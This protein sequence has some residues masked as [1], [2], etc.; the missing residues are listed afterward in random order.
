MNQ[1]TRYVLGIYQLGVLI[2]DSLEYG[3]TKEK[4]DLKIYNTRKANIKHCVEDNSPFMHFISQQKEIGQEIKNNVLNFIDLVYGDESRVAHVENNELIVD[5][6]FST[7]VFDYIVG[8]H[9]TISDIVKGYVNQSK[10]NN[11]Y[12]EKLERLVE[13]DDLFYRCI[14]SLVLTDAIHR[15]YLEF[16][17]EMQQSKGQTTPQ[18]T[19]VNNELNKVVGYFN[20]VQEHSKIND[21]EFVKEHPVMAEEKYSKNVEA[22]KRVLSL[23]GGKEKLIEGE[24]LRDVIMHAHEEWA[25][26][27][28][29]K[30]Y[31]WRA[32]YVDIWQELTDF[33]KSLKQ[34]VPTDNGNKAN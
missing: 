31:D 34:A 26:L 8:L 18:A 11:T 29:V 6:A 4:Y 22:S 2:R 10:T 14:T 30:E 25:K 5:P 20:F 33:E 16:N 21:P 12:D 27:C 15:F 24:N 17:R 32:I 13:K 7:Q 1:A 23:M 3:V 19:F 28:Q 9:E